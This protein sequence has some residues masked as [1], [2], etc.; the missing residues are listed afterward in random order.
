MFLYPLFS[1]SV[2]CSSFFKSVRVNT[3]SVGLFAS[4]EQE[5]EQRAMLIK[6]LS[7]VLFSSD[8]DQ[9]ER[10][11]HQIKGTLHKRRTF[12]IETFSF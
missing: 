3:I 12:G 10:Q 9:Y 8:V 11:L 1:P 5:M 2:I 7:F 4:K 6:R